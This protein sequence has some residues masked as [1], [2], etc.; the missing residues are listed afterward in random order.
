MHDYYRCPSRSGRPAA[1]S[2]FLADE[3][4]AAFLAALE[5]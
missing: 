1:N 5:A 4:G 3:E 2:R